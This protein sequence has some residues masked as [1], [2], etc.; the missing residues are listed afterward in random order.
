MDLPVL[1]VGIGRMLTE[2][3][4]KRPKCD[5]APMI[6]LHTSPIMSVALPVRLRIGFEAIRD[7]PEVHDDSCAMYT[8]YL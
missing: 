5:H 6:E 7:V 8:K 2:T 4:L 1:A 3:C